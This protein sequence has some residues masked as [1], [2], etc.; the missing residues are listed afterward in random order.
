MPRKNR[1]SLTEH[2]K[3]LIK[4]ITENLGND[5]GTKSMYEL[6]LAAGYS[7]ESARQQ[8]NTL[9]GIRE[10]LQPIV[11][12]MMEHRNAVI[13]HMKKSINKAKY[14]D[15]TDALD[16]LTKNIQLLSG[17]KTANDQIKI[18]WDK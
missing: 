1:K 6:M 14:R 7:E 3:K 10:E 18:T 12:E 13:A 16:K 15:L 2:Q 5:E 17:G 9:A 8:S 4:L 11:Q